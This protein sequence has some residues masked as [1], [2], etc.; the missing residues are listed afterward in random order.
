MRTLL[1]ALA[2]FIIFHILRI[3]FSNGTIPLAAFYGEEV[4]CDR[5]HTEVIN[6]TTVT[7]DTIES[8][9]ALY[10]DPH[11]TFVDRLSL[12]YSLNPHLQNQ[13]IVGGLSVKLP[14][15]DPTEKLCD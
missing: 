6:V 9:F 1:A 2:I 7:G 3:D 15:A 12:F 4:P 5:N 8:L 11:T 13:P 10:P 14:L